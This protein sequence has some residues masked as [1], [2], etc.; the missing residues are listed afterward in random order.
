MSSNAQQYDFDATS[1]E[2]R[3]TKLRTRIANIA[4]DWGSET[5]V[6]LPSGQTVLV[7]AKGI[8]QAV[9]S[10]AHYRTDDA[11]AS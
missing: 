5:F 10:G 11:H 3:H 4:R 1:M 2:G 7:L 6:T 8:C 9:G